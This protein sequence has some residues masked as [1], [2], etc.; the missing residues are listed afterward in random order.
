MAAELG[1]CKVGETKDITL[2]IKVD[3]MDGGLKAT[4]Q[5]V[6]EYEED[7]PEPPAKKPAKRAKVIEEAMS[8]GY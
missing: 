8:K 7:E 6:V 1:D 4:V 5:N 2:R 3:S